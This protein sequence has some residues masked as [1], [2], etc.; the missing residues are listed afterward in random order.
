MKKYLLA[1]LIAFCAIVSSLTAA[2]DL[3]QIRFEDYI[4][5]DYVKS[6]RFNDGTSQYS[7]PITK[8]GRRLYLSFD[9]LATDEYRFNYMV[10]HCDRDWNPS[11]I[12][13]LEY[14]RGFN[15]AE[16]DNGGEQSR[17]T[18]VDY[19][20]YQL[21]L[22]NTE[23]SWTLS[24]NYLLLVYDQE[25]NPVFTRRF[26]IYEGLG[27]LE[28]QRGMTIGVGEK[29]TSQR[30]E[31]TYRELPETFIEEMHQSSLELRTMQ[32][33]DWST[34]SDGFRPIRYQG[35]EYMF[36]KA[37]FPSFS[38]L[39]DFRQADTRAL[40]FTGTN[41]LEVDRGMDSIFA[42]LKLDEPKRRN[43]GMSE[44]DINGRYYIDRRDASELENLNGDNDT[45]STIVEVDYELSD[46]V[47]AEYVWTVFSVN[48]LWLR[49]D[50]PTFVIGGFSD[51]KLYP[52]YALSYDEERDIYIGAALMKQGRYDFHFVQIV[53]DKMD[54]SLTEKYEEQS[55]QDYRTFVYYRGFGDEYDRV[56]NSAFLNVNRGL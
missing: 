30:I 27:K 15:Y 13:P 49:K 23:V 24:G 39:Q 6:I 16:M 38:S 19:W 51:Y 36:N 42:L 11:D 7:D 56:L 4:Y 26:V 41:L 37:E 14:M 55:T 3:D 10:I 9:D 18:K 28:S 33:L 2:P 47:Y 46:R 32:N 21:A 43:L 34:M 17:F 12:D 50:A 53:D 48:A 44:F 31:T 45:G 1:T 25:D 29:N 5:V 8:L 52:E 22:P 20:H 54:Y 35:E 40:E